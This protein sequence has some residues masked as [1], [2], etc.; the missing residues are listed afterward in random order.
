MTLTVES[1]CPAGGQHEDIVTADYH[2]EMN[3][4]R[5]VYGRAVSFRVWLKPTLNF[6]DSVI[7]GKEQTKETRAFKITLCRKCSTLFGVTK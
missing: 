4:S 3:S 5:E 6:W 2:S 1:V 7:R